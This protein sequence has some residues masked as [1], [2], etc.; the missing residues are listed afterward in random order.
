MYMLYKNTNAH[1]RI[2]VIRNDVEKVTLDVGFISSSP[3]SKSYTSLFYLVNSLS[4]NSLFCKLRL[5]S[6]LHVQLV[7]TD[8]V[9]PP[10]SSVTFSMSLHAT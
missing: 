9:P 5:T 3:S 10:T 2:H 6:Y 8:S 4:C 7:N 1:P